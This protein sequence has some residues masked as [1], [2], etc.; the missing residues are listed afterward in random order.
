MKQVFKHFLTITALLCVALG[1]AAQGDFSVIKKIEGVDVGNLASPGN[2]DYSNGTIT[3][4]P[5]NGYYLTAEDIT[6]YKMINGQYAQGRRREP[7]YNTQVAI[8]ASDPDADPSKA[9]TY[10]FTKPGDEYDYEI[11]ANFHVRKS[12]ED[13]TV[14]GLEE[15]YTYTGEAI[16][17]VVTVKADDNTL[18]LGTDYRAFYADSINA[19]TDQVKGKITLYGIRKYTGTKQ[20]NYTIAKADPTLTFSS[21]TATYTFGQEFTKPT[22]TTTPAGLE[23]TYTSSNENVAKADEASGD[24]TPV[25]AS[26]EAITITASFAG[27][28]NYNAEEATYALTVAKGTAVVTKVPT[29]KENLTYTSEAQAL[30]NVGECTTGNMQYKVGTNGTYSANIPTGTDAKT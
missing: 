23:V 13:A 14:T 9:T 12:V 19:S 21:A 24:I 3:V 7:S 15:S 22:L 2:V 20:I 26:T 17:P 11:V 4:T 30:I 18:T 25:A 16:K 10:T 29:A 28:D 8:T 1:A 27:N 5:E 6:V